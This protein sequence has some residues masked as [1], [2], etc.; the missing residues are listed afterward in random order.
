[1]RRRLGVGL[2]LACRLPNGK[3]AAYVYGPTDVDEA[4]R[5]MY[6]DGVRYSFPIELREGAEV[7]R[8][9]AKLLSILRH[10]V[11]S[12]RKAQELLK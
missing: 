2:A 3:V 8:L 11:K 12:I 4:T 6:P 1:M 9:R 10:H 5:L 7:G